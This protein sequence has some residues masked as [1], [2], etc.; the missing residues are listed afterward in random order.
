MVLLEMKLELKNELEMEIR[1]DP[2]TGA[3]EYD[4]VE[5]FPDAEGKMKEVEFGIEDSSHQ[6]MKKFT[7]ED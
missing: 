6:D 5:V 2:E 1:K 3:L 7:Y 4:E